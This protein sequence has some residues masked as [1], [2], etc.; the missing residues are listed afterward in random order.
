MK[1][2]SSDATFNFN[3]S[4]LAGKSVLNGTATLDRLVWNIGSGDWADTSWVGQN[5]EV[6]VRVTSK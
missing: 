2:F 4:E 1:N 3:V 6:S 5:V